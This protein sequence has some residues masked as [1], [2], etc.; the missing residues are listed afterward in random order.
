MILSELPT[1]VLFHI[2]RYLKY[3]ENL[4]VRRVC[5]QFYAL[6]SDRVFVRAVTP[7]MDLSRFRCYMALRDGEVIFTEPEA[8]RRFLK[9][10][11]TIQCLV[12]LTLCGWK[13]EEP[14]ILALAVHLPC[15]KMLDVSHCVG[16]TKFGIEMLF[17]CFPNVEEL[18]LDG[19]GRKRFDAKHICSISYDWAA[20]IFNRPCSSLTHLSLR[21]T[22]LVCVITTH[23][24][25]NDLFRRIGISLKK[26]S[27]SHGAV[28]ITHLMEI[29]NGSLHLK[30]LN[31]KDQLM[32]EPLF[33]QLC[34][35]REL[36]EL[37]L[38]GISWWPGRERDPAIDS[39]V[40]VLGDMLPSLKKLNLHG[41]TL[42]P[43]T[44][45]RLRAKGIDVIL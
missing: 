45:T 9:R 17:S 35:M 22:Q 16:V 19:I 4:L 7:E 15:L 36:E 28:G 20:Q 6:F 12:K 39:K 26:L 1:D 33:Q 23:T 29:L 14:R 44:I 38:A 30:S 37:N 42:F 21:Q 8:Q 24:F 3:E 11:F 40:L 5:T 13:L 2:N 27:F 18:K 31:L 32:H 25:F 34:T 41:A 10:A 43:K